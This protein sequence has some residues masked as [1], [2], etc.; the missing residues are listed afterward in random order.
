ML[1]LLIKHYLIV[2]RMDADIANSF[3]GY[4][5]D[6]RRD[7]NIWTWLNITVKLFKCVSN[8]LPWSG[9][10]VMYEIACFHCVWRGNFKPQLKER[11]GDSVQECMCVFMQLIMYMCMGFCL[12]QSTLLYVIQQATK[13]SNI[14]F[15]ERQYIAK[16]NCIKTNRR[17]ASVHK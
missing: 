4:Y 3:R 10:R 11:C 13:K 2:D 1:S 16:T 7:I 12:F 6:L 15:S 5:G 8:M 17:S 9:H 14:N